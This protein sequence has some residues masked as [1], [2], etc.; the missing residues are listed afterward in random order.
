MWLGVENSCVPVPILV[1]VPVPILDHILVPFS[2]PVP[3]PVVK[4]NLSNCSQVI[5]F[6]NFAVFS[7]RFS[8]FPFLLNY[9]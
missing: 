1:Y 6:P 3:S 5:D 2:V 7:F 4:P 8:E 9:L